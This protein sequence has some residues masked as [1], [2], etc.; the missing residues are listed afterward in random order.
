MWPVSLAFKHHYRLDG[1]FDGRF[2]G[3]RLAEREL[4]EL[5]IAAWL[6]TYDGCSN[7][8]AMLCLLGIRAGLI[9]VGQLW[10]EEF[11]V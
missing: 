8:C 10:T 11:K 2:M 4:P 5:E 9:M 3:L 7:S 6:D 1:H